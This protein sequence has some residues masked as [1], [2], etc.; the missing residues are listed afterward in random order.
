MD[1]S[2]AQMNNRNAYYVDISR[3]RHEVKI[4][5]DDKIKI[6]EQVKDFVKKLTSE[7]FIIPQNTPAKKKKKTLSQHINEA[8]V[9]MFQSIKHLHPGPNKMPEVWKEQNGPSGPSM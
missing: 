9:K 3:A 2:Q 8:A 4:F 1:S 6:Q 7:D 5:T